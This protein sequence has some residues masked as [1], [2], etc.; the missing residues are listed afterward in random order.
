MC[1]LGNQHAKGTLT[2][3]C[4]GLDDVNFASE[5]KHPMWLPT[6]GLRGLL[7]AFSNKVHTASLGVGLPLQR[8]QSVVK[9]P[10]RSPNQVFQ[11]RR[12]GRTGHCPP[13]GE[14]AHLDAGILCQESQ[15]P[16]ICWVLVSVCL[17]D[18]GCGPWTVMTIPWGG[19]AW[20]KSGRWGVVMGLCK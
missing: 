7:L 18:D 8:D 20:H 6:H 5:S 9:G 19:G 4:T 15:T 17:A 16:D 10:E 11:I 14:N 3:N 13:K 2:T 1:I 12:D